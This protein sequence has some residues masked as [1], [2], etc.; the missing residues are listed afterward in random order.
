[1]GSL[2][3]LRQVKHRYILGLLTLVLAGCDHA[4]SQFRAMQTA[5]EY[6]RRVCHQAGY[7]QSAIAMDDMLVLA[8]CGCRKATGEQWTNVE[9]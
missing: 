1:M 5:Q 6:C 4:T 9:K 2:L 3:G 7:A 8:E